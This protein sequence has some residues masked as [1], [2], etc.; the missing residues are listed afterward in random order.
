MIGH[1]FMGRYQ[2][3]RLLGEGGMGQVF[4]CRQRDTGAEVVVKVMRA[5]LA[6]NPKVR[7]T[8]QREMQFMARFRHPYAVH[9]L[10]GS[11]NDSGGPCIVME[12]IP[13]ATLEQLLERQSRIGVQRAGKMLGQ[14][15]QALQAAHIIGLVHQDLK[16]ANIMVVDPNSPKEK[17]KVMDFGLA[18]LSAKPHIPLEKLANPTAFIACGTPDYI[19]PEMVRG[20]EVDHR[21]DLYAVGVILFEMLTGKRPFDGEDVWEVLHAHRDKKPPTFAQIGARW[22]TPEVETVVMRCLSKF[23]NERPQTAIEIAELFEKATGQKILDPEGD[24]VEISEEVDRP[25]EID[26]RNAIKMELEAWMPEKIAVVKL[27]GFVQ[28]MGGEIVESAPGLIR[29]YLPPPREPKSQSG[30]FDW[31]GLAKKPDHL[32]T[33]GI[34]MELHMQKK[35]TA[36][37]NLLEITVLL[38]A[39]GGR[40]LPTDKAWQDRC[41]RIQREL[42]AYLIGSLH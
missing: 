42:R 19:S 29:V 11:Y 13:G 28:D 20:D 40:R 31:L 9:L 35:E 14:L 3:I 39:E 21:G 6:A 18:K 1:V 15:C 23:P 22:V 7:E 37:Q 12:Y 26:D 34:D 24:V 38:R 33:P 41:D 36:R 16:P 10:D 2:V 4:L 8:F 27:R 32:R 5:D 30:F 25:P 17:V